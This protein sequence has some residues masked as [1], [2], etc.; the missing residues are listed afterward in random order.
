MFV[1]EIAYVVEFKIFG[2]GLHVF[3]QQKTRS[4]DLLNPFA[5]VHEFLTDVNVHV[6]VNSEI[7]R[8]VSPVHQE[9]QG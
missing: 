8:I 3:R 5:L 9:I 1:I 4:V 7:I 6:G 2:C